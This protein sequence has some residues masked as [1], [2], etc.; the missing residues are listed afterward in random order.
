MRRGAFFAG[1]V[2]RQARQ[3]H[4][5]RAPPRC[6]L[7]LDRRLVSRRADPVPRHRRR[8]RQLLLHRQLLASEA[9]QRQRIFRRQFDHEALAAPL[10][11]QHRG[12]VLYRLV[13]PSARGVQ[14]Q[15]QSSPARHCRHLPRVASRLRHPDADRPDR[16][17]LSSL[18]PRMGARARRAD[19]LSRGLS[20]R[21]LCPIRPRT[22]PILAPRSAS[23]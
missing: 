1:D 15:A 8:P 10:V 12:A 9:R 5:A 6:E 17:L 13:G 21:G 22:S 4:P 3:A 7:R 16:R 19:R 18:D 2:L 20:A 23:R 14:D 11:A